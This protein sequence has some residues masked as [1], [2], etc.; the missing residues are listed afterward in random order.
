MRIIVIGAGGHGQVVADAIL[1]SC[2]AQSIETPQI[3]FADDAAHAW[4]RSI[5]GYPVRGPIAEALE[6]DHDAVVV[7]IGGNRTRLGLIQQLAARGEN[8]ISV[9]HPSAVVARAVDVGPGSM[10]LA[11][12]IVGTGSQLGVGVIVNTCASLD[13]H[14]IVADYVH[15]APGAHTGGK[16][17]IAEGAFVGLGASILPGLR[18]GAWSTVGAGATVTRDVPE[19]YTV[20]GTPAHPIHSDEVP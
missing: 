10:L 18:I 11:N 16:V 13:H 2:D 6:S 5:L 12:A 9:I 19:G 17:V 14:S 7:A 4:S 8:L 15:I 3:L 1:A 20:V